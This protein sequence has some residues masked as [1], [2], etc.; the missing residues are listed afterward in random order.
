MFEVLAMKVCKNCEKDKEIS[1]FK[2][3]KRLKSGIASICKLCNTQQ[4]KER[5]KN[6]ER[7]LEKEKDRAKNAS[8]RL[9][10]LPEV[11]WTIDRVDND[12]LIR[13]FVV[14][15]DTWAF[16]QN[17]IKDWNKRVEKTNAQPEKEIK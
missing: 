5:A 12:G 3:D 16:R 1:F 10:S 2:I 17:A 9:R 11:A 14:V 13:C 4:Q 6:K 7:L 8:M 15:V